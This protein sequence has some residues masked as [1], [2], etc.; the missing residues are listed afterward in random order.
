MSEAQD[1]IDEALRI[2]GGWAVLPDARGGHVAIALNLGLRVNGDT[3]NEA[4]DRLVDEILKGE[5]EVAA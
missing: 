1:R 3:P 2:S 5:Q 4:R